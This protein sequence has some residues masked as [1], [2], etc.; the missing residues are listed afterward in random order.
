MAFERI[1]STFDLVKNPKRYLDS[2]DDEVNLNERADVSEWKDETKPSVTE[3][4]KSRKRQ[5]LAFGFAGLIALGVVAGWSRTYFPDLYGNPVVQEVTKFGIVAG[6][7]FIW[8]T[9][10]QRGKLESLG[11]L[12]MLIPKQG[13]AVYLG[14]P[15]TDSAGN[16][17]FVPIK[18]FDLFGLR[19]RQLK[20]GEFDAGFAKSFAKQ[21]RD[22]D[23]P[24]RIRVEDGLAHS[25]QT[26]IGTVIGVLT[27]GLEFDEYGR[28]SDLYTRPPELADEETYRRLTR[29]LESVSS[30]VVDLR[31]RVDAVEEERDYWKQKALQ[32]QRSIKQEFKKDHADLLEAGTGRRG[33]PQASQDAVQRTYTVPANG[34]DPS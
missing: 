22:A 10:W 1:K 21:G 31:E 23:D 24:A 18:G 29:R 7:V 33:R 14:K 8:A 30:K 19:G 6:I 15:E 2:D 13:L 5:A 32:D 25:K 4:I 34:D 12:V 16:R 3:R 9:K 20:L 26:A 28:E 17:V 11:I 27:G